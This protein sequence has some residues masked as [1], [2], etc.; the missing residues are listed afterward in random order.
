MSTLNALHASLLVTG[1]TIIDAVSKDP[2]AGSLWIDSGKI[3]AIGRGAEKVAPV[4]VPVLDARGKYVIPG[5]MDANVHLLLDM[6]LENLVRHEDRFEDLIAEAAQIA[7][8]NGLTTVFDTWGPRQALMTVRDR[9]ASGELAGSRIFCAG[10]I[11]GLD[12]P[13]SEDFLANTITVASTAL[14]NRINS[15]WVENVGPLLT[16]VGPE[17]VA[18][19]VKTYIARGIDFLKFAGSEHRVPMGASAFLAFSPRCQRAIVDEAHRAGLTAQAH[20]TSVEALHVAVEAGADIIQH[21]NS[22]GPTAIPDETLRILV[23]RKV[24]STIFPLTE[25]RYEWIK[26]R[27]DVLT[28][29]LFTPAHVDINVRKLIASGATILLATDSG[30]MAPEVTSDLAFATVYAGEDNLFELGQGH[31]HWFTAMEEKGLKPLEA[32]RAATRNIAAAYGKL[33]TLGTLEAGKTADMVILDKNPLEAAANYRSIH[34]VVKDGRVVDRNVL[35]SHPVLTRSGV[36]RSA[37][38]IRPASSPHS[39]S[40]PGCC[41]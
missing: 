15:R 31:F 29:R 40:F 9:I 30:V 11:I 3:R 8:A 5:L 26:A 20:T 41:G 13:F 34:S 1:A 14:I 35:P 21:C 16:W 7:L 27:G 28:S 19:E 24:A 2:F 38:P 23:D 25:R 37:L 12:G 32:L 10:N 18:R 17:D 6:R 22:T 4:D 36:A 33:D 39:G